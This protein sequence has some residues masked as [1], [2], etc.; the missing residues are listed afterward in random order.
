MKPINKALF[1]NLDGTLIVTK[2]GKT[3]PENKD[4]WQFNRN[5][6]KRIETYVDDEYMVM[7]VSNQGGIESGQVR[8]ND[9]RMKLKQ[10]M[11]GIIVETGLPLSSAGSRFTVSN[12][13]YDFFR[14]PNPGMAYDLALSYILN[15]AECV[16]VG[17]SSGKVRKRTL[18]YKDS[19]SPTGWA[20]SHGLPLNEKEVECVIQDRESMDHIGILLTK[21]FS[22][23]DFKFAMNAGMG[24]V[25]VEDFLKGFK[26]P[27][28]NVAFYE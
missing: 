16:M 13:R 15:L 27:V 2:S 4:D 17:N 14:K 12:N 19:T 11:N 21:D 24:Y 10:V 18:V 8:L 9:F 3:F 7:V 1:L 28:K 20:N 25:D 5:I 6:L 23:S 26:E 22:N